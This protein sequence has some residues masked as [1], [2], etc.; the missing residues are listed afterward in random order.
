L[1]AWSAGTGWVNVA[2]L[3]SAVDISHPTQMLIALEITDFAGKTNEEALVG[4]WQFKPGHARRIYRYRPKLGARKDLETKE[5]Q[6]GG[7]KR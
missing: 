2:V 4:A 6:L 3:P 5:I 7:L 1:R